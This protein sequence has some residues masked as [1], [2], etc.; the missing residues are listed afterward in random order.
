MLKFL[1]NIL[2]N[3]TILLSVMPKL[4]LVTIFM[5]LSLD[6]NSFVVKCSK[7]KAY[8]ASESIYNPRAFRA[9]QQAL[10]PSRKGPRASRTW[11][12]S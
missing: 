12:I 10:D 7:Y 4:H 11:V 6:Y 2:E 5:I 9:L 8:I 3:T 1:C